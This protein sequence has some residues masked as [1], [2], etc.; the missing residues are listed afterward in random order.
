MNNL[1]E[2]VVITFKYDLPQFYLLLLSIKKYLQKDI[3]I[4]IV[5]NYNDH[6][7]YES[8][9]IFEKLIN[10]HLTEHSFELIK[11]PSHIVASSGWISQQILKWLIAYESDRP[12][13]IVL[14][15]KNFFIREFD[16]SSI[17]YENNIIPGFKF[18]EKT[19]IW[20]NENLKAS[21]DFI[22][23]YKKS[24][25]KPYMAL[26]PWIWKT[27][28]VR[29][30][31][32]TCWPNRQWET[33]EILP[34]TEWFLYLSWAYD[35][36]K[37]YPKQ[38]VTGIWGIKNN[39]GKEVRGLLNNKN[40]CFWVNHRVANSSTETS[41]T[42]TVLKMFSVCNEEEIKYWLNLKTL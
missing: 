19:D 17:D 40:I 25:P 14:D 24:E 36:V 9:P 5:F 23:K 32:D 42:K 26:T 13:Q 41:S 39:G 1:I 11:K 21:R 8:F 22:T 30:M 37:Y 38:V 12:W 2:V 18:D 27:E 31:L 33:L 4:K 34:G 7:E 10:D 16:F 29:E 3:H 15:S 6:D 35:L 28:T 20:S